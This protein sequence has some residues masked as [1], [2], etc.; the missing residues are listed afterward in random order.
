[1]SM[2][3][4]YIKLSR[5]FFEHDLWTKQRVFSYAE[6]WLDCIRMAAYA[7]HR[8][9]IGKTMIDIPRGAIVASERFLSERWAWSRTKIRGFLTL[10]HEEQ[11]IVQKKD[12]SQT[13]ITLCN[14]ER[15]NFAQ[16]GKEPEK[17]Q[18]RTKKE[19][20]EDQIEEG[21]EREEG[22]DH[23]LSAG[24]GADGPL[25][26]IEAVLAFGRTLHP[27]CDENHCRK[28]F[29]ANESRGWVDRNRIPIRKW[30]PGLSSWW[31]GVQNNQA[32]KKFNSNGQR[33]SKSPLRPEDMPKI[34]RPNAK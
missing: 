4:G 22:E 1:M 18:E 6:A 20:R 10:L 9:L 33:T 23:T 27:P 31:R 28:W 5:R 26:R 7:P 17:N 2:D 21:K 25:P 14:F 30:K 13:V 32:E 12:R 34:W 16:N 24:A 15:Y 29:E 19:P 11:M 3:D 8:R